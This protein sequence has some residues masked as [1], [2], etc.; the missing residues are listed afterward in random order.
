MG[1]LLQTR[2]SYFENGYLA[3]NSTAFGN[4]RYLKI[5]SGS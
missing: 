2:E 3:M 1:V 4:N 5:I